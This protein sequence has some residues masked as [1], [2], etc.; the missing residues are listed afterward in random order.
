MT[1]TRINK[2]MNVLKKSTLTQC[3]SF[4]DIVGIEDVGMRLVYVLRS[5]RHN[6][7]I[8][9]KKNSVEEGVRTIENEYRGALWGEREVFDMFGIRFGNSDERRILTDYGFK[10][11]PLRKGYAVWE[12]MVY[13]AE[14]HGVKH[15]STENPY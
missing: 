8:L 12:G 9:V 5:T 13:D 11:H 14:S 7:L 3:D 4:V 15:V 1:M 2:I 6:R 10:G